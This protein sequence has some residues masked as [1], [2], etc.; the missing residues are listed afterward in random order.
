MVV[1]LR[2]NKRNPAALREFLRQAANA[3]ANDAEFL[4]A[5]GDFSRKRL[6]DRAQ[7]RAMY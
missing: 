3:A 6:L 4:M 7:A 2:I 5:L 1:A